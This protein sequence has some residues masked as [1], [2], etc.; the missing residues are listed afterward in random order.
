MRSCRGTAMPMRMA[1]VLLVIED[2]ETECTVVSSGEMRSSVLAASSMTQQQQQQQQQQCQQRA[3]SPEQLT[4]RSCWYIHSID[5]HK[6]ALGRP[7]V[8]SWFFRFDQ[9]GTSCF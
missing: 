3:C 9:R 2:I 7:F 8:D 6:V 1:L 5:W 4:Y